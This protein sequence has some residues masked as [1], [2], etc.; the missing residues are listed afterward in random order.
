[1]TSQ[2]VFSCG[3]WGVMNNKHVRLGFQS[4]IASPACLYPCVNAGQD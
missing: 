2:G 3:P 1:M 4:I